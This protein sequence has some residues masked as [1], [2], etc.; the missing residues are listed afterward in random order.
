LRPDRFT[1][2]LDAL[3]YDT[4]ILSMLLIGVLALEAPEP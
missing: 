4:A 3:G 1:Q 2:A